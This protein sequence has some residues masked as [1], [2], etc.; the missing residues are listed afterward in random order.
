MLSINQGRDHHWYPTTG[1][2]ESR[3]ISS[4][5]ESLSDNLLRPWRYSIAGVGFIKYKWLCK[6]IDECVEGLKILLIDSSI[7]RLLNQVIARDISRV[8][9][10]H[11]GLPPA[12]IE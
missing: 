2:D 12:G 3:L 8:N 9:R 7:D 6:D 10:I 1:P 5:T 4:A 11:T